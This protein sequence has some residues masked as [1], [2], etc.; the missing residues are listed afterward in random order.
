MLLIDTREKGNLHKKLAAE[1]EHE[2]RALD[3]GDYWIP[4]EDGVIVIERSSY[5]DFI[6][7][8]MSGR[9]WD[10]MKKCMEKSTDVYFLLENPYAARFSK[11]SFKATIGAKTSLSRH[12]K[13]FETRNATESFLFIKYLYERLHLNKKISYK[14]TRIKPRNMSNIEQAKYMLM[15]LNG[16]GESTVNKLFD[17][18]DDLDDILRSDDLAVVVGDRLAKQIKDVLHATK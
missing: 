18:Y 8:I 6:G 15:G 12:V 9:L 17:A 16:V 4:T 10:Q 14:E 1:F 7:K 11:F 5:T 2:Y 3:A 13:I